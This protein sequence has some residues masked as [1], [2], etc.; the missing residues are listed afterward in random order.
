M[1]IASPT[2]FTDASRRILRLQAFTI[3]WM[4]FEAA[5]SLGSAWSSRSPALLAFG[6]DSLVELLGARPWRGTAPTEAAFFRYIEAH[7][8]TLLLD[9]VEGLNAKK[10]SERDTAVLAILN[11][12]YQKGQTVP[13]CVGASHKLQLFHVYGPKAFAWYR[14]CRMRTKPRTLLL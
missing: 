2:P 13:R 7:K 6:G 11:A 8:P 12:G 3:L 10:V 4:T 5:N 9:E 1:A 14:R